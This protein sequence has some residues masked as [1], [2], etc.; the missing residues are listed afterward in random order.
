MVINLSGG[1]DAPD[2]SRGD[3]CPGVLSPFSAA[4]GAIIRLRA[5]G[6]LLEVATLARLAALADAHGAPFL[7]LTSRG[8]LQLRGL[9][10]P[11]GAD[12]VAAVQETGLVPSAAH[13]RMRNLVCSPLTGFEP[14]N[15]PTG[16]A[17]RTTDVRG[18]VLETDRQL[19]ADRELA[20]L[21]G[22]FLFAFDD[23]RGDVL[24]EHWDLAWE[25]TGPDHGTLRVGPRH[26]LV[27]LPSAEAPARMLELARRF[28]RVRSTLT[29][30]P[31]HI[32]ELP[33]PTVL[34]EALTVVPTACLG[35]QPAAGAIGGSVLLGV[36][37]GRLSTAQIALLA[38]LTDSVVLTPWR[39]LLLPHTGARRLAALRRAGFVTAPQDTWSK[40]TACTGLPGCRKSSIDT[41]RVAQQLVDALPVPPRLSVHLVGCERACG[42]PSREHVTLVAP[43]SVDEALRAL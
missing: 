2:R 19:R 24:A 30:A 37:L 25:A 35:P 42:A 43:A 9:P 7:Q 17:A 3:L 22:R 31:W 21:P 16:P 40:V 28:Q 1:T 26:G 29:P 32:R 12:L 4:D 23:G 20:G 38:E 36:P 27:G 6:G 39:T 11:L 8:N 14:R 18:L 33:D 10:D 34:D 15:T 5:P 13:E 41:L